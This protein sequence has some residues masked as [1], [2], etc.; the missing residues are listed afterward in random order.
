[1]LM[2]RRRRRWGRRSSTREVSRTR[3]TATFFFSCCVV[4]SV[5][6][7]VDS[8]ER[9]R[10]LHV[11]LCVNVQCLHL[12]F[13]W[14]WYLFRQ[15][16]ASTAKRRLWTIIWTVRCVRDS[17]INIVFVSLPNIVEYDEIF[18]S[19]H[20]NTGTNDQ[21]TQAYIDYLNEG[22]SEDSKLSEFTAADIITTYGTEGATDEQTEELALAHCT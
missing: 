16:W 3:P 11:V 10:K 21:I 13:C 6:I 8:F 7:V 12:Y 4:A 22:A 2:Q 14:C 18:N 9:E 17:I 1:M 5:V 19:H 20:S 15:D